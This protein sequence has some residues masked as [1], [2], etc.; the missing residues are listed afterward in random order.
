MSATGT[1]FPCP[2]ACETHAFFLRDG[3]LE[4]CFSKYRIRLVLD[5]SRNRKE[6]DNLRL[7]PLK[8]RRGGVSLLSRIARFPISKSLL[9]PMRCSAHHF[10]FSFPDLHKGDGKLFFIR[11]NIGFLSGFLFLLTIR[12]HSHFQVHGRSDFAEELRRHSLEIS[13]T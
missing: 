9:G 1:I 6:R 10:L 7:Y 3:C 5:K 13:P 2:D 4:L 8:E 11:F 12:H